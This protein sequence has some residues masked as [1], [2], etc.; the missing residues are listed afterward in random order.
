MSQHDDIEYQLDTLA[1]RTGHTRSFEGEH[2]EPIFLTSSFVYENAAEAA[3]KFSGAEPGNIY[4]RFT[5]PTVAMF[6]T[7]LAALEGGERAVATSSGMAAIMAVAMSFLKAGDHVICSRAVFG[8]TVSLFEKYVAKF[9]VAVTFVDL[10][11]LRAWQDAVRPETRLL[12]V[13]SPSN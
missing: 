11:D 9:N 13:E 10:T 3:A 8:S 4:S 1:I 7:R 6:E 2:S 12:F 5:N